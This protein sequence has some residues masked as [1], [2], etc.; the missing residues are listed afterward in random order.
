MLRGQ[1]TYAR[2]DNVGEAE[3]HDKMMMN[4]VCEEMLAIRKRKLRP[5]QKCWAEMEEHLNQQ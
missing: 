1:N 4:A 5:M 3:K 2:R